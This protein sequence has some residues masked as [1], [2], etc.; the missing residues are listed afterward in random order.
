[1]NHSMY[2]IKQ[3]WAG[4]REK[5]GFLTTIVTTLGLTLGALLCILTLAYVMILKPLP[6]PEQEKLFQIDHARI[7]QAEK[8]ENTAFSPFK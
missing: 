4:L 6:Y 7:N 1:M 8:I 5:K 3:A 2:L